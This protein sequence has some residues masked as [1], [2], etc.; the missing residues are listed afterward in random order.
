V[1]SSGDL[2]PR[3]ATVDIVPEP[4]PVQNIPIS[5]LAPQPTEFD[6]MPSPKTAK[7]T[8]RGRGPLFWILGTIG[9]LMLC[10]VSVPLIVI[11]GLV[12]ITALGTSA[13]TTF[14]TVSGA[15]G[16]A[17]G[18]SKSSGSLRAKAYKVHD[19]MTMDQ[20]VQALG[21]H[22]TFFHGI[23]PKETYIWTSD[24]K[25]PNYVVIEFFNGRVAEVRVETLQNKK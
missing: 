24:D 6:F 21:K 25:D 1:T 10:L 12:A 5:Q 22:G 8:K 16:E 15:I 23:G 20:V 3:L 13:N 7:P 2:A 18:S 14:G 11:G 9:S 19:G 17:G 4:P